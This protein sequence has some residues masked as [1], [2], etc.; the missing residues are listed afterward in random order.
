MKNLK[1]LLPIFVLIIL[2]GLGFY[3]YKFNFKPKDLKT[4]INQK[5]SQFVSNR[6]P[7]FSVKDIVIPNQ[8]Q[9]KKTASI[10][11]KTDKNY[12]K[13]GEVFNIQ[14]IVSGDGENI[15]GSEF[16]LNF[17]PWLISVVEINEG[18]FF[19]LYP[20]KTIDNQNGEIRVV[21]LQG[22]NESK[23]L[24]N[25]VMVTLSV[26]VIQAGNLEFSFNKEK[27]HIAAYGGQELLSS[28]DSLIVELK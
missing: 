9:S 20:Q 10:S 15:D 17:N 23:D 6:I 14:V 13:V 3:F 25:E 12:Y 5:E 21:A 28:V 7:S 22:A 11:L 4:K 18:S 24:Y 26:E 8:P 19:S 2:L 16:L 27:T 1:K